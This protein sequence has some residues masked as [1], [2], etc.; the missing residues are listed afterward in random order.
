[1]AL[2]L[3]NSSSSLFSN[4]TSRSPRIPPGSGALSIGTSRSAQNCRLWGQVAWS[5][6][7]A[8]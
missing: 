2:A 6:F 8:L 3:I 7:S 4:Q 5:R 1:M